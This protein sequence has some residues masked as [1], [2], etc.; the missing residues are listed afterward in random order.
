MNFDSLYRKHYLELYSFAYRLTSS[1]PESEDIVHE[2]FCRLL[3]HC[4]NSLEI[5]HP[6]A[7]L[8]KVVLN[9]AKSKFN[10]EK[11]HSEKVKL[12]DTAEVSSD[13][14]HIDYI[15]NEKQQIIMAELSLLSEKDRSILILYKQGL[16]YHEIAQILDMNVASVG[17]TLARAIEKLSEN[18]KKKYHELF[19]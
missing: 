4:Q 9:I 6:R 16:S 13:D 1:K 3:D 7:W 17:T 12:L 18:L 14:L 8:Y 19:E 10:S 5:G 11:L 15:K 2:S